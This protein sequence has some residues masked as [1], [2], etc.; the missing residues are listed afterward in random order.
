MLEHQK[1]VLENI[2]WKDEVFQKEL[3]KS[4]EWLTEK[5]FRMLE[6]W[7]KSRFNDS[8]YPNSDSHPETKVSGF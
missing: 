4:K 5:E 8:G 2:S 1:K 6:H 7:L 3:V